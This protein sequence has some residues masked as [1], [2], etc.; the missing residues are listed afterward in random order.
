MTASAQIKGWC[1]GALRPMLSGDGYLVRLRITGG[2]VSSSVA[3]AIAR[4]AQDFGN[5]LIDL[6]ARANLQLRGVKEEHLPALVEAL[7]AHH[8]IDASAEAEAVRNVM[9]SPLAGL[10]TDA[11]FDVSAH[12][13]ALERRLVDDVALHAL[14]SKFGFIIDDGGP[15]SLSAVSADI[16]FLALREGGRLSFEVRLAG[17]DDAAVIEASALCDVAARLAKA[18]LLQARRSHPPSRRMAG[19]IATRGAGPIWNDAG[20]APIKRAPSVAAQPQPLGHHKLGALGW[21]GLGFA[22]GRLNA[23]DLMWLADMAE[24]YGADEMRLT[25]WRAVLLPGV[26][27]QAAQAILS[28]AG[29]RVIA[30]PGDERLAVVACPGHPAC[31]SAAST[32]Q[33]DALALA[34]L[35]RALASSGVTL[36]VSGCAKGCARPTSTAVTLTARAGLYDLIAAGRASDAPVLQSLDLDACR[37][38]LA[39]M[40][41]A[42]GSRP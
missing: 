20:L 15:L 32:T 37:A 10:A 29:A 41:S 39:R 6:S 1:P 25:P 4:C 13:H 9:A 28:R 34:P 17:C 5:G 2:V 12:V 33:Q 8:L 19:L 11:A 42:E 35:A 7:Q 21:L 31:A 23:H 3:T 36:H 40:A 26:D 24:R 22:F 30:D 16:R 38:A 18:F 14:P 27:A